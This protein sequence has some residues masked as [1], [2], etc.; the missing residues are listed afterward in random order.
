MNG[1]RRRPLDSRLRGNDGAA[2][3]NEGAAVGM[4]RAACGNDGAA[5]GND[6]AACRMAGGAV[7]YGYGIVVL[8]AGATLVVTTPRGAWAISPILD[9]SRRVP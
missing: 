9:D 7:I 1:A 2:R 3:G 4:I 5:R 6:A 8:F